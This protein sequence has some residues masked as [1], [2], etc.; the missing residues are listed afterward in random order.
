L[1]IRQAFLLGF[2]NQKGTAL[3]LLTL[4]MTML[5]GSAALVADLGVNYF[6]QAR[7]SVAADAAALAGGTQLGAGGDRAIQAAQDVAAKN[8]IFADALSVEVE[9]NNTGITVKAKAPVRLFFGRFFGLRTAEMEQQAHVVLARPVSMERLVPVG[10]DQSK[11]FTIGSR[12]QLFEKNS[13]SDEIDLGSG[14]SGALEF[15][16][17]STGAQG[18]EEQLR[19]GWSEPI[20]KG[21]ILETKSGVKFSA[22]K[23]AMEDR[24][25]RAAALPHQCA[26]GSCP[27][28]CPRIVYV[29]VYRILRYDE[30]KVSRVEV[31]DFAAFWLEGTRRANGSWQIEKEIPGI[32]IGLQ[33]GGLRSAVGESPYG[34]RTGK[35][36]R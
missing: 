28:N 21:D 36:I 5:L 25:T 19:L 9:P 10:I 13:K 3:I 18:F 22:V 34:I 7:L 23:S 14:N 12:Q 16:R 32:F 15:A 27:S 6:T 2:I 30:N 29:P 4:V 17:Q 33:K 1:K 35:L 24:L 26:P 8:G 20:S 31:V 11:V